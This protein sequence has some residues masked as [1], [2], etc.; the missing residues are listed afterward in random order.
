MA[1]LKQLTEEGHDAVHL[2]KQVAV[3]VRNRLIA[4]EVSNTIYYTAWLGQLI[5]VPA[6]SDPLATLEVILLGIN[7]AN[8][9][10]AVVPAPK[11]EEKQP[12]NATAKAP[13]HAD[14][15]ATPAAQIAVVAEDKAV[16]SVKKAKT[17]DLQP[18]WQETLAQLRKSHN[19][20]YGVLRM[21]EVQDGDDNQ[22][23][24]AF[25]FPF[26][27]KRA[28]DPK[29]KSLIAQ[30]L[31]DQLGKPV[32]VKFTVAQSVKPAKTAKP[33]EVPNAISNIFCKAEVLES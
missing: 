16:N 4:G 5:E 10:D 6:S 3:E 26:H 28:N 7:L 14:L 11:T 29:N 12:A 23:I 31:S 30:V 27:Q 17:G 1:N 21:A 25:S 15:E 24:L 19:T 32:S 8:G 2:A 22:V 9:Q 20:L 13:A 18:A 33:A